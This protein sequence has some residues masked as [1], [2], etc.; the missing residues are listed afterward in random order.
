[1]AEFVCAVV[2]VISAENLVDHLQQVLIILMDAERSGIIGFE[3]LFQEFLKTK[4]IEEF[5]YHKKASIGRK[6]SS[7]KIY[8]NLL[9]AFKLD[10]L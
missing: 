7:V 5:L 4:G 1:M 9:I 10:F 2:F 8:K 3:V 6:F